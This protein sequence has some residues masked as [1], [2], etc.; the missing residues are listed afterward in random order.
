MRRKSVSCLGNRCSCENKW[1]KL[2]YNWIYIFRGNA[3]RWSFPMNFFKKTLESKFETIDGETLYALLH[4]C[5]W[6]RL[7]GG[8]HYP[9][10]ITEGISLGED[11][12]CKIIGTLG[13]EVDQSGAKVDRIYTN[14]KDAP[15]TPSDYKQVL[16]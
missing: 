2:E 7:Y 11:I 12:A 10:D 13:I 3:S 9:I 16:Y 8:V 14:Y 6:S 1:N 4:E 5:A 15:I